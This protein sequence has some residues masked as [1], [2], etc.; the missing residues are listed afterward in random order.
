[1]LYARVGPQRFVLAAVLDRP[2]KAVL[3]VFRMP[4]WFQENHRGRW[5]ESAAVPPL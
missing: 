4:G 1:M 5:C 2:S 3:Q